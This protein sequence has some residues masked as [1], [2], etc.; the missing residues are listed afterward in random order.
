MQ[1]TNTLGPG[2][3]KYVDNRST[4]IHKSPQFTFPKN[5]RELAIIDALN[6]K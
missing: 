1:R 3:Y 2:H 4:A 5:K 6:S